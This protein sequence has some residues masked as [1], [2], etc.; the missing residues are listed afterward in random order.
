MNPQN[1]GRSLFKSAITFLPLTGWT[2]FIALAGTIQ[3]V[4]AQTFTVLHIFTGG[5]DGGFPYAGLTIDRGGNLYGT[6]DYGGIVTQSCSAGCGVVFKLSQRNSQWILTPLYSFERG[7]DGAIPQGQVAIGPNGSIYGT[8]L[9]GG[10]DLCYSGGC[11]TVFNLRPPAR[12][13]GNILGNW[14]ETQLYAF[15]GGNDGE[16]PLAGPPVFDPDGNIYGTTLNGG[17][18]VGTVYKLTP[19]EGAWTETILHSFQG[20]SDGTYPMSGLFRDSAGNLYGTTYVGGSNGS[21]GNGFGTVYELT[22][23]GS[24]W[25]KTTL[26]EFQGTNDGQFPIGGLIMDSAGNLFGTT[27]GGMHGGATVF[28]LTPT[29]G[30]WDFATIYAFPGMLSGGG[31]TDTLTMDGTGNLY[32]TAFKGGAWGLG[33][34]FRLAPANG[35]WAYSDLHDFMPGN[36]GQYP[37]GSVTIDANGDLYG[38][39]INGGSDGCSGYGCGTAWKIARHAP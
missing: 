3:P 10:D 39:T 7:S 16:G 17:N 18:G 9:E 23:S 21:G 24:G 34:V 15:Q 28:E 1:T 5:P 38:T 11:G 30:G 37:Y 19:T 36:Y 4:A 6:T 31:P 14:G 27:N 13:L 8:T 29:Q 26:Y 22:P 35:G 2:L 20:G 12:A 32:G 25:T 33:S